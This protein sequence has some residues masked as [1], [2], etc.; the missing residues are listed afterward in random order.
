[1]RM[2]GHAIHDGAEYV[3]AEL[4][5][6]WRRRDPIDRYRKRLLKRGVI[7]VEGVESIEEECAKT[8]E[9]AVDFAEASDWPDPATVERGVYA[10]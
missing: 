6:H 8:V 1:M 7:D 4:L 3:P 5:E 2:L 9:A 10:P